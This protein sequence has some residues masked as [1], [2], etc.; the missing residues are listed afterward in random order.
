MHTHLRRR[1]RF[2]WKRKPQDVMDNDGVAIH[3]GVKTI[4]V[5]NYCDFSPGS[6]PDLCICI[7]TWNMNGQVKTFFC[8]FRIQF[9]S[10]LIR[11]YPP[12]ASCPFFR[13]LIPSYISSLLVKVKK[14]LSSHHYFT[15][16]SG[17]LRSL[18]PLEC[19]FFFFPINCK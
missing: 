3:E 18:Q 19:F 6:T 12:I 5:E 2:K 4:G 14:N 17:P 10:K 1:S 15:A 16:D 9:F 13:L 7:V 11:F 8:V